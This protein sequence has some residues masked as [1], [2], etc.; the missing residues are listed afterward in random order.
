[1]KLSY[2]YTFIAMIAAAAFVG[3]CNT[4]PKTENDAAALQANADAALASYK[5]KDSSL[6]SLLDKSVGYA[7]FP[8]IGKAGWILGGSYGKGAVYE[9]G[10]RVGWADISEVSAG[11]QWGAQNFSELLVF[12]KREDLERFKSGEFTVDAKV[13]AVALTAGAAAKTDPAKGVI[14]FVDTKGGLMAEAA[15][16]GQ[17]IRFRPE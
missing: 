2:G 7:V 1:M 3:G 15:V 16:G 17:R 12:M 10:R 9:G 4:A 14:A 11:F 8:D 13:S 5:A 6:Q